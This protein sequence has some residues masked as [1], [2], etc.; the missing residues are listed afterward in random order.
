MA[1]NSSTDSLLK[2][3]DVEIDN[4][5]VNKQGS[6]VASP[7]TLMAPDGGVK[8][9]SLI[10]L[11]N[12]FPVNMVNHNIKGAVTTPTSLNTVTGK[13]AVSLINLGTSYDIGVAEYNLP[14][15]TTS[16]ISLNTVSARPSMELIKLGTS[17]DI[18]VAEYNLPGVTTSGVTLNTVSAKPAISLIRI[19][20]IE[21]ASTEDAQVQYWS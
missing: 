4:V 20:K 7:A 21:T 16:G 3:D 11:G 10:P 6:E 2:V 14:G 17:Y 13:P 12:E 8:V 19:D 1:Y 9:I 5:L 15:V 18:N